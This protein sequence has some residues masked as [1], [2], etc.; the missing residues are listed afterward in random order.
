MGRDDI[1]DLDA[2]TAAMI[3]GTPI[4]PTRM[5]GTLERAQARIEQLEQAIRAHRDQ[6]LADYAVYL[7]EQTERGKPVRQNFE[8]GW[9]DPHEARL[10]AALGDT[11]D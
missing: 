2:V 9:L 10:Y 3:A 4:G 5:I 6:N 8:E 7:N 1:F 11:D